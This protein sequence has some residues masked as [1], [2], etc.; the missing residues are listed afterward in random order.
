MSIKNLFTS[1]DK[2][3]RI[4]HVRNLVALSYT[5]GIMSPEEQEIILQIAERSGMTQEEL[6]FVMEKPDQI[7]F[8]VPRKTSDR[9]EEIYDMVALM[10]IDG[11]ISDQEMLLCKLVAEKMHFDPVVID[12]MIDD[13]VDL[14][15]RDIVFEAGVRKIM[16]N[17]GIS[18]EKE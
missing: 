4:S 16:D 6:D 5:D 9:I 12:V 14:I 3:K 18:E 1:G 7:E 10:M 17:A 11:G 13:M 15:A 2:K 8:Y